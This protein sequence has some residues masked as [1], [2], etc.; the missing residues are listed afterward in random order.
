M[1]GSSPQDA[2]GKG[3]LLQP[4]QPQPCG[5]VGTS[6]RALH[7]GRLGIAGQQGPSD[8]LGCQSSPFL[9]T[10]RG[11]QPLSPSP[12]TLVTSPTTNPSEATMSGTPSELSPRRV[13]LP[14]RVGFPG[15]Q[16][17]PA[18]APSQPRAPTPTGTPN[19][20]AR[21]HPHLLLIHKELKHPHPL[22]TP[23]GLPDDP[24]PFKTKGV[25]KPRQSLLNQETLNHTFEPQG[26]SAAPLPANTRD[27]LPTSPYPTRS[28]NHPHPLLLH[29]LLKH[30]SPPG[31]S[32]SFP[33]P[34]SPRLPRGL[35][36]P[37]TGAAAAQPGLALVLAAERR[38]SRERDRDRIKDKEKERDHSHLSAR[39]Q[40]LWIRSVAT[41]FAEVAASTSASLP[42]DPRGSGKG[43][44]HQ[45]TSAAAACQ[46]PEVPSR[47]PALKGPR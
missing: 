45:S 38:S 20:P 47:V 23:I 17:P 26:T 8:T 39:L 42:V 34:S 41:I 11:H 3:W 21:S 5:M 12:G 6:S 13:T 46:V 4:G 32:P 40:S 15:E 16:Q 27:T 33:T 14:Y 43:E 10:R 37:L 2:G 24:I 36:R 25:P 19:V 44:T 18:P 1:W 22:L 30:P 9:C 29:R 35:F 7:S 31:P 28:P